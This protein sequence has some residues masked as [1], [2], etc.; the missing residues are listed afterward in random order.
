M[1]DLQGERDNGFAI[2]S[3]N[4]Q[5]LSLKS[6]QMRF[7]F[8]NAVSTSLIEARYRR[9]QDT[10]KCCDMEY[11]GASGRQKMARKLVFDGLTQNKSIIRRRDICLIAHGAM[12][13]RQTLTLKI[14]VRVLVGEFSLKSLCHAGPSDTF[15]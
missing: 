10:A 9:P 8:D 1:N 4:K 2:S 13:A 12:V 7:A 3:R 6:Y 15:N 11:L 5:I 14:K